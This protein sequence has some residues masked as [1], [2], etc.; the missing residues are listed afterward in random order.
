MKRGL[1]AVGLAVATIL[2][3]WAHAQEQRGE[4]RERRGEQLREQERN[5]QGDFRRQDQQRGPGRQGLP[6]GGLP[7]GGL[8]PGAQGPARGP[9]QMLDGALLAQL[10]GLDLS[11]QQRQQLRELMQTQR[12]NLNINRDP[13]ERQRRQELIERLRKEGLEG[14]S[15]RRAVMQE[16]GIQP[17]PR[18]ESGR[19]DRAAL[20]AQFSQRRAEMTEKL[21]GILTAE[22]MTKLEE[23]LQNLNRGRERPGTGGDGLRPPP[24]RR[25]R[26]GSGEQGERR[27]EGRR[28]QGGGGGR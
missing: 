19:P 3:T 10:R 27:D 18:G 9:Q 11:D 24:N 25:D 22:Q 28:R 12:A 23:A 5:R 21:R 7:P 14:E 2:P 17:P 4:G 8:P 13:Q 20:Q 26:S 1:I 16:M 6:P 15:L